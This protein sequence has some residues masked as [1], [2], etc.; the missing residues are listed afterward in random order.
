MYSMSTTVPPIHK[1]IMTVPED[2]QPLSGRHTSCTSAL[3][4][5]ITPM[6]TYLWHRS[7]D[8]FHLGNGHI[9]FKTTTM[10]HMEYIWN[11][12]WFMK[13]QITT[14]EHSLCLMHPTEYKHQ[15]NWTCQL[16]YLKL[17]LKISYHCY[18]LIVIFHTLQYYF[19]SFVD[20]SG[21]SSIIT[22][23]SNTILRLAFISNHSST[24]KPYDSW[25]FWAKLPSTW[26]TSTTVHHSYTNISRPLSSHIHTNHSSNL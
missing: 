1:T 22:S 4:T 2:H 13:T 24:I 14:L 16:Y 15:F 23:H 25:A 8:E 26:V 11:L 9:Y 6:R 20:I 12:W 18:S 17:A 10:L 7:S 19:N 3:C 21:P 5:W